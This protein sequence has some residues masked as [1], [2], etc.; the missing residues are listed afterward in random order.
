ME[1]LIEA[2]LLAEARWMTIQEIADS[3]GLR[4][5]DYNR[6]HYIL[7]DEHS[8]LYADILKEKQPRPQRYKHVRVQ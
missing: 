7:N 2:L 8:L 3:L 4:K 1:Q 6:V 5:E